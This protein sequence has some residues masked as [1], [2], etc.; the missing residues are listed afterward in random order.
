MLWLAERLLAS[1]DV[2][3]CLYLIERFHLF[4]ILHWRPSHGRINRIGRL[5]QW[6]GKPSLMKIL[7]ESSMQWAGFE[8]SIP[9]LASWSE[10]PV[11]SRVFNS[12]IHKS[13]LLV[14]SVLDRAEKPLFATSETW[15]KQSQLLGT[16]LQN[17]ASCT[18][19]AHIPHSESRGFWY[20]PEDLL[21]CW[22]FRNI[23]SVL[24]SN[25]WTVS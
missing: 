25:A 24:Q 20:R 8:P 1:Q 21:S 4:P 15:W 11:V 18:V 5:C 17:V 7:T 13:S 3:C 9:A 6:A 16:D 23:V 19:S 14:P 22:T 10:R 12:E 2:L